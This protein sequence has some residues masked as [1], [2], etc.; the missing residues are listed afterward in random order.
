VKH[1]ALAAPK[2]TPSIRVNVPGIDSERFAQ[3]IQAEINVVAASSHLPIGDEFDESVA[4]DKRKRSG[5]EV[6]LPSQGR[7]VGQV[8]AR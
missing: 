7:I 5:H 8:K 4:R 6:G 2:S 1:Q 3:R